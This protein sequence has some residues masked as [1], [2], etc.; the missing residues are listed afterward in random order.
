MW[1]HRR[2]EPRAKGMA[3]AICVGGIAIVLGLAAPGAV[4]A[5]LNTALWM[6]PAGNA[7][8]HSGALTIGPLSGNWTGLNIVAKSPLALAATHTL[9][10]SLGPPQNVSGQG[11][12]AEEFVGPDTSS[13]GPSYT[14]PG[15]LLDVQFH[16]TYS[17]GTLSS[18]GMDIAA[19]P[20]T[21]LVNNGGTSLWGGTLASMPTTVT[22]QFNSKTFSVT[23]V[24]TTIQGAPTAA[25]GITTKGLTIS[26]PHGVSFPASGNYVHLDAV[27]NNS[28]RGTL[29]FTTVTLDGRNLLAGSSAVTSSGATPATT[30][31]AATATGSLPKTG[32]NPTIPVVGGGLLA[33]AG[34][35]VAP[36]ILRRGRRRHAVTPRSEM[37][38]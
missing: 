9:V 37:G 31:A 18:V 17:G 29:V 11:V 3:S 34:L 24:G 6:I 10:V 30:P 35:L 13:T 2:G 14:T 21:G 23:L 28:G 7:A 20:T 12:V 15:P 26:G 36:D 22:W 19:K 27:N 8:M 33:L 25:A 1:G 38:S 5:S 16:P 32:E 4:A